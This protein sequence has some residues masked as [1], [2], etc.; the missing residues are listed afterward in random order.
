MK[1]IFAAF[2]VMVLACTTLFGCGS[3]AEKTTG[4][5]QMDGTGKTSVRVG[6]L[7]ISLNDE[8][9][10][11]RESLG[12]PLEYVESKSC[13]YEGY[14]KIYTYADVEIITYPMNGKEY[15]SSINALTD[16]AVPGIDIQIGSSTDD[17]VEKYGEEN[18]I[19][20][21]VYYIY[22]TDEYGYSFYLGDDGIVSAIEVYVPTE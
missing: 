22:E 1:K 20:G 17:I 12:E 19:M 18:L 11:V 2:F 16:N 13:M 4:T 6:D 3:D 5:N 8:M 9:D 15:I 10:S 21:K 7:T 14:D